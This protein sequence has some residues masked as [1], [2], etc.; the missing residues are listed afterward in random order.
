MAAPFF[1]KSF[2][3]ILLLPGIISCSHHIQTPALV[4]E[5]NATGYMNDAI[6]Y[7]INQHRK[8]LGLVPLKFTEVASIQALKHS[9]DMAERRTGFG[10]EG[11]EERIKKISQKLGRIPAAAENVAYGKL[12]AKEV[13]NGWLHSPGHKKN[14]EGNYTL[15]GIGV[16]KNSSDVL[17]FTQLFLRK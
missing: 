5:Q 2:M 3:G 13:V 7:Y 4:H 12:T 15:T 11:F 14:I 10:H 6:L 9:E 17:F 16:S 8:S 1:V